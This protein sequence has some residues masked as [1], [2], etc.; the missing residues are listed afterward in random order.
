MR[1]FIPEEIYKDLNKRINKKEPFFVTAIFTGTDK[2]LE[3]RTGKTYDF[4]IDYQHEFITI[5]G[6]NSKF[7]LYSSIKSLLRNWD[8]QSIRRYSS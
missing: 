1:N 8:I 2:S 7:C 5:N 4:K 3:Y 6:I